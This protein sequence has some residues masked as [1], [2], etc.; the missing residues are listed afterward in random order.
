M[1]Q[2][3][4]CHILTIVTLEYCSY[5]YKSRLQTNHHRLRNLVLF[6]YL[7]ILKIVS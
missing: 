1:I 7:F 2:Q 6:K 5:L 3:Y 4:N